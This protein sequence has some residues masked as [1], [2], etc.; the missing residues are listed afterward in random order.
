MLFTET[1]PD[2]QAVHGIH[3]A[4]L[5]QL[6]HVVAEVVDAAWKGFFGLCECAGWWYGGMGWWVGWWDGG[7]QTTFM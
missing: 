3:A 6:G 7:A 1:R 4:V 5:G 2:S